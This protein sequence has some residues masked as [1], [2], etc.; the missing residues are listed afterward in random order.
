MTVLS[1][2]EVDVNNQKTFNRFRSPTGRITD[3][4][5]PSLALPGILGR[6]AEEMQYQTIRAQKAFCS[7][8]EIPT[9]SF[10]SNK[11]RKGPSQSIEKCQDKNQMPEQQS[12]KKQNQR[13]ILTKSK[14]T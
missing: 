1:H 11:I 4:F 3:G 7:V 8:R 9:P 13:K 5:K 12:K 10:A 6:A 14:T 2:F